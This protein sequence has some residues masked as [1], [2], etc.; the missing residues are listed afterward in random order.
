MTLS[1][2]EKALENRSLCYYLLCF[3]NRSASGFTPVSSV[4]H[5][6]MCCLDWLGLE[7]PFVPVLSPSWWCLWRGCWDLPLR[8]GA[9][10]AISETYFEESELILCE[11]L[12]ASP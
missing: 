1:K 2:G 8:Q 9:A 3:Y 7:A 11:R 12:R 4:P 10:V 6:L 5:G